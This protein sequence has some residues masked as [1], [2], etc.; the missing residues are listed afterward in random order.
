[1]NVL[2]LFISGE[3]QSIEEPTHDILLIFL[4]GAA[5]GAGAL[6]LI[7]LL[8]CA[9]SCCLKKQRGKRS[10]GERLETNRSSAQ[11]TGDY[12]TTTCNLLDETQNETQHEVP[13][14]DH[15]RTLEEGSGQT[16]IPPPSLA[17]IARDNDAEELE[18]SEPFEESHKDLMK[19]L[20]QK[21][22]MNG[23]S[24]NEERLYMHLIPE[25][26]QGNDKSNSTTTK[27]PTRSG[28][29]EK[30]TCATKPGISVKLR[31]TNKLTST[32]KDA[33][34]SSAA[35]ENGFLAKLYSNVR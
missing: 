29:K 20:K 1:M 7:I 25:T 21:L 30:E 34:P 6:T 11:E 31:E 18:D 13:V 33:R 27:S 10:H 4:S 23:N 35:Y 24:Q 8:L 28:R 2:F 5:C 19:S 15:P 9:V 3:I 14:Y 17:D 22:P 32:R 16:L 12:I 26:R